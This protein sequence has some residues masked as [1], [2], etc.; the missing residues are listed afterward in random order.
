MRLRCSK[1]QEKVS[2]E[3]DWSQE[4]RERSLSLNSLSLRMFVNSMELE[5]LEAVAF[6]WQ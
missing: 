1:G 2:G 4:S 5:L 6:C 3:R